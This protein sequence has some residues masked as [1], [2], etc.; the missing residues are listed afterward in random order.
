VGADGRLPEG[1]QPNPPAEPNHPPLPACCHEGHDIDGLLGCRWCG[2]PR[3]EGGSTPQQSGDGLPAVKCGVDPGSSSPTEKLGLPNFTIVGLT[4]RAIQEARERVRACVR[5]AG[6]EFPSRRLTVNLAPAEVPKEGTGFDLPIAMA[7]T[8]SPTAPCFAANGVAL[9]G[10][11]LDLDDLVG[12]QAVGLAVNRVGGF[13]VWCLD[14]AVRP[15]G[16]RI[17]PV[18]VI[19]HPV[20]VLNRKVLLVRAL[21]RLSRQTID[22]VVG[23]HEQW[24]SVPP[25]GRR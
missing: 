9:S 7:A 5:N 10:P 23:I 14:Q 3:R 24:Q 4:E 1:A 12:D 2:R 21:D 18:L 19:R 20:L 25:G 8:C 6:F 17:E 13:L 22:L 15:S 11:F 16:L